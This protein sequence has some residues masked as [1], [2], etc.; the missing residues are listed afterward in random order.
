MQST[1]NNQS[2]Q[3]QAF[4]AQLNKPVLQKGSTGNEV[5]ELQKLLIHWGN[6][7]CDFPIDGYFS[8]YVE[9]AVKSFQHRLFLKV[10]GIVGSRTWKSLYT[11][12][13]DMPM[14]QRGSQ[15]EAVKTLQ[16]ALY[17][18]NAYYGAI[19]GIFGPITE[20]AVRTFQKNAGLVVDGIAGNKTW[21]ALSK[22]YAPVGC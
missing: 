8:D 15:G 6:L 12:A 21:Y 5:K 18:T 2:I 9:K 17:D 4:A 19:D 14:L 22:I 3:S 13:P 10:D 20:A 1:N 7:S 11:G 16:L